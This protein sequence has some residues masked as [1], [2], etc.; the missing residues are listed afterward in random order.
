MQELE[1]HERELK[2]HLGSS[3]QDQVVGTAF[4][5]PIDN[6]FYQGSFATGQQTR[7]H[8][9]FGTNQQSAPAALTDP[10]AE[11]PSRASVDT[12]AAPAAQQLHDASPRTL[13]PADDNALENARAGKHHRR[14]GGMPPAVE[15]F[16]RRLAEFIG[17]HNNQTATLSS[18]G[19]A[20][21][22][23]GA[24]AEALK[25]ADPV[26]FPGAPDLRSRVER[27]RAT[28]GTSGRCL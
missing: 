8:N 7:P 28:F 12:S 11:Y 6:R 26:P 24:S 2:P 20:E 14:E 9:A 22:K 1:S 10:G 18:D 3:G 4:S 19:A 5:A 25:D 27:L 23:L 16:M 21:L 17:S 13:T 15:A